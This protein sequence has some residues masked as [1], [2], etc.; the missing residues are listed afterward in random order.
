MTEKKHTAKTLA[1]MKERDVVLCTLTNQAAGRAISAVFA[2]FGI[3]FTLDWE[4]TPVMK[5]VFGREQPEICTVRT[6][7]SQ[8]SRARR[9]LDMM[10]RSFLKNVTIHV[11]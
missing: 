2:E 5:R 6:H 1:G 3:P 11:L 9:T 4:R 8:Y 10:G 7:R